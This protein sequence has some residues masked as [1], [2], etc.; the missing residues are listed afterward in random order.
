[1]VATASSAIWAGLQI[2]TTGVAV[3]DTTA[4]ATTGAAAI[5]R[6]AVF[7][8]VAIGLT[9]VLITTAG[10]IVLYRRYKKN[11]LKGTV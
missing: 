4:I 1:M 2:A 9:A 6:G 10:G 3:I 11:R 8:W 7:S 5:S